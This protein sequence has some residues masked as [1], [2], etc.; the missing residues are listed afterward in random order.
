LQ[1]AA[2][3]GEHFSKSGFLLFCPAS[4]TCPPASEEK[5]TANNHFLCFPGFFTGYGDTGIS[6]LRQQ[7]ARLTLGDGASPVATS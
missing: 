1:Q 3:G 6:N 4:F 5:A 2:Q 7:A